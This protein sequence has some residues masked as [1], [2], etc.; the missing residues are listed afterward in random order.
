MIIA[1]FRAAIAKSRSKSTSSF[2]VGSSCCCHHSPNRISPPA[3]LLTTVASPGYFHFYHGR[4]LNTPWRR[5]KPL[6]KNAVPAYAVVPRRGRAKGNREERGGRHHAAIW[7]DLSVKHTQE[8]TVM[9][10]PFKCA[11]V[12]GHRLNCGI[13]YNFHRR[14]TSTS[15]AN[16]DGAILFSL[17]GKDTT[18]TAAKLI[19]VE[20]QSTS[21]S[22]N[23]VAVASA[24][25][26]RNHHHGNHRHGIAGRSG[27]PR[28]RIS[29]R[30][31]GERASNHHYSNDNQQRQNQRVTHNTNSNANS[32]KTYTNHVHV[33]SDSSYRDRLRIRNER[34]AEEELFLRNTYP[35]NH[36][37]NMIHRS[38]NNNAA[39]GSSSD[40][41]NN[42]PA[43]CRHSYSNSGQRNGRIVH[44]DEISQ[45]S[46]QQLLSSSSPHDIEKVW[47]ETC[48]NGTVYY[49]LTT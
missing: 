42:H 12:L 24:G 32:S 16:G 34:N 29:N 49:I 27:G 23:S 45:Q 26:G 13:D 7:T 8:M 6:A 48:T 1:T 3:A 11:S 37:M 25:G 22:N 41:A 17:V 40:C 19:D 4:F 43:P 10:A 14:F 39:V 20:A 18:A 9:Q 15:N 5:N 28:P 21:S 36:Y 47:K 30:L 38:N 2:F 44:D 31:D 33:V 46:Q 35:N